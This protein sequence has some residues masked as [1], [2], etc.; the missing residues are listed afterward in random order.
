MP[1]SA[2]ILVSGI[3]ADKTIDIGADTSIGISADTS[4]STGTSITT[5]YQYH[6]LVT[7]Q[8]FYTGKVCAETVTHYDQ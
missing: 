6:L 2:S 3:I 4:F 7:I 8:C 1:I 5:E